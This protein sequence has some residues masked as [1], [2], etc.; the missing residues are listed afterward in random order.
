MAWARWSD[1]WSA[2]GGNAEAATPHDINSTSVRAAIGVLGM[3]GEQEPT[4]AWGYLPAFPGSSAEE[5]LP[6][7]SLSLV[8]S[9]KPLGAVDWDTVLNKCPAHARGD[10]PDAHDTS[11]KGDSQF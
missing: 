10:V 3:G 6:S 4:T 8:S 7:D 2:P 5:V 1:W 9:G 11:A